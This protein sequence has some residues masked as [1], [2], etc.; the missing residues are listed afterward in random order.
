MFCFAPL[1]VRAASVGNPA[2]HK[3]SDWHGHPDLSEYMTSV[4]GEEPFTVATYCEEALMDRRGSLQISRW[5]MRERAWTTSDVCLGI[6]E[7]RGGGGV[8]VL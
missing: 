1:Q 2:D 5:V 7:R 6:V 8:D 4:E 3:Y